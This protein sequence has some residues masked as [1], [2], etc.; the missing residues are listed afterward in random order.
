MKR[1][2]IIAGEASS[3]MHAANLVKEIKSVKSD[4]SFFGLGG[5]RMKEAGVDIHENIVRLAFMGP[6]GLF[7]HYLQLKKIFNTLRDNLK[8]NPPDLAVLIDYAEFN[9]RVAKELKALGVP[10]VY[11]V[12]PQVWAWG[13]WRIKTIRRLV[14]KMLVFFKFEET[15]YKEHGVNVSFVGHPLLD[16]VKT[17]SKKEAILKKLGIEKDFKVIGLLPGS[18]ESEIKNI[19][20]VMLESAK[21]IL[22]TFNQKIRFVLPMAATVNK[23]YVKQRIKNSGVDV[24]VVENDTYNAVSVCNCAMVTSG[25]ATLETALLNVPM[26]IIY[27]ANFLNYILTKHLIKLPYIG[28]VNVISGK[29]VVKEFLQYEATSEKIADY[30]KRLITDEKLIDKM[31]QEFLAIRLSLERPGAVT[32]AAKEVADFLN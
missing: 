30:M 24:I 4:V 26:A 5:N 11:Y 17:T 27:K 22:N 13:L 19:L 14:D 29:H 8:Q 12:S 18:R 7:K 32:R 23:Q 10:V 31:K 20:P 9:L 3:D 1:I 21:L 6:G 25:T 16:M 15:L 28:L 2:L